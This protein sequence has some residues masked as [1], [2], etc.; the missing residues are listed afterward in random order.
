MSGDSPTPVSI[1][2]RDGSCRSFTFKPSGSGPW[3]A[4]ILYMDAFAI[5]PA[6]FALGRH[7]AD[8]GYFVLVPD[9]FYRSGD[10]AAM[11]PK[12]IFGNPA[13]FKVLKEKFMVRAGMDNVMSDTRAFLDFL[14]HQPGA[15]PGPV[16]TV[17]YCMGGA[18][19]LAAAGNF[20]ER[21]AASAS[22]HGGNLAT[23]DPASPHRLAAKIRARVFIAGATDDS[24]FPDSMKARLEAALT[25]VSVPHVIETWPAKHGWTFYDTP[26]YDQ[27]CFERHLGVLRQLFQDTLGGRFAQ[28]RAATI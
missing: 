14:V 6:L 23:D 18:F 28:S 27:A 24:S 5:R 7:I 9:L 8:L 12:T 1:H 13:A 21:V 2:T 25:Q 3:P 20:P 26:V 10:Y 11:D 4:V 19:A 22:F 17:G 15:R 16:G